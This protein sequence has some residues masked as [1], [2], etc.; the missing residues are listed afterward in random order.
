M[1]QQHLIP[2]KDP[3]PTVQEAW[4]ASGPVWT[5]VENLAPPGF[6]PRT[7]N[8]VSSHYTDY[9]TWPTIKW[10]LKQVFL[11]KL[12]VALLLKTVSLVWNLKAHQSHIS[13]KIQWHL[14][15][16]LQTLVISG[17]DWQ[18]PQTN[19]WPLRIPT[20]LQCFST[21]WQHSSRFKSLRTWH[22]GS[23]AH[24]FVS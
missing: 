8:P 20:S 16:L 9:A 3:V 22:H 10:H 11:D 12:T 1:P 4:W 17:S 2:G 14:K 24:T 6:N 5:G 7:V 15:Q 19:Q 13:R 21:K 18:Q 23:R